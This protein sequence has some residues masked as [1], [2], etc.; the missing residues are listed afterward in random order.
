MSLNVS[1][2][3]TPNSPN[4]RFAHALCRLSGYVEDDHKDDYL[5]GDGLPK[6]G[7]MQF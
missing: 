2:Y 5:S 1:F 3:Y 7:T 6:L 4:G